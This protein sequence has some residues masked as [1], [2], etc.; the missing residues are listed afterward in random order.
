MIGSEGP[1]L[2]VG[3][4]VQWTEEDGSVCTGWVA[5]I[6]S[7]WVCIKSHR[8]R[9]RYLIPLRRVQFTDT[10]LPPVVIAP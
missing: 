1:R 10:T 5:W 9:E 4:K 2:R 8:T 7:V 6:D 3:S